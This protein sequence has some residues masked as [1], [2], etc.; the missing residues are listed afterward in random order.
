MFASAFPYFEAD[1]ELG[2]IIAQ[3]RFEI[4]VELPRAYTYNICTIAQYIGRLTKK[5]RPVVFVVA[6][7]VCWKIRGKENKDKILKG[8]TEGRDVL[9][10]EVRK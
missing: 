10:R 2:V 9:F 3:I 7:V 8:G 1:A 5:N 6:M 4:D